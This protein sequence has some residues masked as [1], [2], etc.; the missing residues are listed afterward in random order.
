MYKGD[1][2]AFKIYR[3]KLQ[4]QPLAKIF[5]RDLFNRMVTYIHKF[6]ILNANQIGFREKFGTIDT[7]A[8]LTEQ[9]RHH[10]DKAFHTIDHEILLVK[11]DKYGFRGPV[12]A[13]FALT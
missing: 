13:L 8:F 2:N 10:V 11:L 5:E 4:L 12:T 6:K 9:I 7:P 3:P 1:A